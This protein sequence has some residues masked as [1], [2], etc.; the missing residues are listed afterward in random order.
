M[1]SIKYAVIYSFLLWLI[2]FIIS[3]A[4]FPF[5]TSE[6]FLFRSLMTVISVAMVVILSTLYF[7]KTEGNLKEGIFLG[8]LFLAIS[9]SFDYFVFIWGPIKM[10]AGSYIKEIGI[11]YLVYPI[12]VIGYGYLLGLKKPAS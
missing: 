4:I 1:K 8:I 9:L 2:P 3:I 12:I 6:P 11:S 10:S 5:K 7:K